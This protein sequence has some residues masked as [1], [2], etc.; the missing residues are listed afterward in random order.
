[1]VTVTGTGDK[2]IDTPPR[3]LTWNLKMIVLKRNFL[4]QGLFSGSMLGFG[5]VYEPG[6]YGGTDFH[7]DFSDIFS[8]LM[9]KNHHNI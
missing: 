9:G 6:L 4:F 3:K 2:L 8:I 5:G 7:F 1:V